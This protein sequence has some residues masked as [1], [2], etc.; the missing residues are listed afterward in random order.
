MLT[1]TVFAPQVFHLIETVAHF[2]AIDGA[3]RVRLATSLEGDERT[4]HPWGLRRIRQ[5]GCI[6]VSS[7]EIANH[8]D[9]LIFSLAQSPLC[10]TY[11]PFANRQL[12]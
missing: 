6:E 12:K 8:S 9:I 2:L 4:E 1:V 10:P 3:C 5:A 11:L 7:Y